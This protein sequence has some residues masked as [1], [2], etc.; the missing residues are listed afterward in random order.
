MKYILH[1]PHSSTFVPDSRGYNLARL[2]KEIN[3]LTDH[4]TDQ[5][6]AVPNIPKVV[7][8]F[9]R[10]FCDPE[11]LPDSDEPMFAKGMGICYTLT[12]D[13]KLLRRLSSKYK[14]SIVDNF[15]TPHHQKLTNLV[16][17]SLNQNNGAIVI[18]CHSF[19]SSPLKREFNQSSNRP[20]IC[21]G[22]DE[23]HTPKALLNRFQKFFT[24]Y[25][26][27]IAIN[28]PYS[29]TVIPLKYYQR[30]RRVQGIMI[31]VN[32][33][34]YMNETTLKIDHSQVK[35]LNKLLSQ[36]LHQQ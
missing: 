12:D 28:Q 22:V 11:R 16:Q 34:L 31:E 19:S 8:N 14:E 23:F 3:L 20:D 7:A 9:S 4:Q 6:F 18:D 27:S 35:H 17:R 24:K 33:R 29:G 30:D 25:G 32:K 15:Y 21:L 1:V 36:L 13:L 10:V 2:Q 5:I 26:F